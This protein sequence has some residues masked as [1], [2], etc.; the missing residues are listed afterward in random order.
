MAPKT[1]LRGK[2]GCALSVTAAAVGGILLVP[3][4]LNLIDHAPE[5]QLFAIAFGL[6]TTVMAVVIGLLTQ[7]LVGTAPAKGEPAAPADRGDREEEPEAPETQPTEV[8]RARP[9]DELRE[10]APLRVLDVFVVGRVTEPVRISKR[11]PLVG[12]LMRDREGDYF[13]SP[14]EDERGEGMGAISLP[15][16]ADED[17]VEWVGQR[18]EASGVFDPRRG[19]IIETLRPTAA[20]PR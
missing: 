13:L 7:R 18:V 9:S 1:R 6:A 14:E 3:L 17:A 19:L 16:L 12:E 15:G 10:L 20:R 11:W 4:A 2:I 8:D 5:E